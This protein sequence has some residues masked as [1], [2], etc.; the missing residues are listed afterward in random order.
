MTQASLSPRAWFLMAMLAFI[1]GGSFLATRTLLDTMVPLHVVTHRV[2]WATLVLWAYVLWRRFPLPRD[3]RLWGALLV[4]GFLNNAVPFSLQATAQTSIESGLAGILNASAAIFGVLVAAAVFADERLTARKMT[5]VGLGF[6]GVVVT[7]GPSALTSF[8]PRSLAQM[9]MLASTFSYALAGAWGRGMLA[10]IR[11]EIAALGML[12]GASLIM[13]PLSW[14]VE[15]PLPVALPL[16]ALAAIAY[17]AVV[18]TAVA[19]LIYYRVLALAGSGNLLLVTLLV[20]P[21]AVGLGALV[22]A[23]T[24]PPRAFAGFAL[25]ALALVVI[26]GRLVRRFRQARDR[27]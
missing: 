22:R 8:D 9:A 19:Y 11:P 5:G 21:V 3:P 16:P 4:M 17:Y 13:L 25:I 10:G 20:V 18:I 1:W 26:D 23:E 27:V 15:G 14:V 2:L 6:A 12:T 24:L 7:M